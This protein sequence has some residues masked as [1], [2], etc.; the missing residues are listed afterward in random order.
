MNVVLVCVGNFQDY[1]LANLFQLLALKHASVYVVTEES[2]FP[3]FEAFRDR[4]EVTLVATASLKDEYGYEERSRMDRE[5]RGGFWMHAS[6][7]FFYIYALMRQIGV[8]D[9]VH[10]EN[11]V[12]IYHNVEVLAGCVDRSK[13][14]IPFDSFGRTIPSI[15]YIPTAASLKTVLDGYRLDVTDMVNFRMAFA[16]HPGLIEPFPICKPLPGFS[17]EQLFVSRNYGRF[18]NFIFDACAMGQYLGGVDPRNFP[19]VHTVGFINETT[20]VHYNTFKGFVWITVDDV[21]RPFLLLNAHEALPIFNLH[22]HSKELHKFVSPKYEG[23]HSVA[24]LPSL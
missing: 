1:I 14:Y 19:G 24:D 11:D 17:A 12:P 13:I 15:V 3:R 22:I 2:F 21:P 6:T 18:S 8:E 7:R 23:T 16:D 20:V 5:Y 9:V 4:P 10:L